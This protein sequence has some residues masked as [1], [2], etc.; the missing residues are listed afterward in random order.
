M[1]H[2]VQM[3]PTQLQKSPCWIGKPTMSLSFIVFGAQRGYQPVFIVWFSICLSL[4]L[5]GLFVT[6]NQLLDLVIY[7]KDYNNEKSITLLW[8]MQKK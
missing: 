7:N 5:T 8:W 4:I 6:G 3:V 1:F 2:N